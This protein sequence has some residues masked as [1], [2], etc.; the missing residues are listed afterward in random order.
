MSGRMLWTACTGAALATATVLTAVPSASRATAH[1]TAHTTPYA[2]FLPGARPAPA[3]TLTT[4]AP[5]TP[6]ASASVPSASVSPPSD[7]PS[8]GPPTPGAPS[9]TAGPSA[10]G[11]AGSPGVG[12]VGPAP[13]TPFAP[14]TVAG[15]LMRLQRLYREAEE[16][17]EAYNATEARLKRQRAEVA[18]LTAGLTKARRAL[19][20]SRV[21]AGR[22]AREQYQ[23][24]TELSG[25][26]RLL[27]A[28]DP[29]RALD[30]N[31][32]LE[33]AARGR[34]GTLARLAGGEKRADA[35]AAASRAALATQRSLA[36]KQRKQR[37]TVR[38]RLRAV[39]KL[40]ASLSREE[41]AALAELERAGT[42]QAQRD[43]LESG[44]LGD[45]PVP[46][47][48]VR[49]AGG[50]P[51]SAGTSGSPGRPGPGAG[52]RNDGQSGGSGEGARTPSR[53][54]DLAL[55]YAVRQIGK[56]YE[57]G[58]EGPDTFDC[59]GLTMQSW[60]YAGLTIPRTSQEQWRQLRR[61]PLRE[62]RPGDLVVYFEKA[63]H[64][65]IYLGEGMVIQAPRPGTRVKVSPIAAN[66]LLGAVRPDP[67]A[68]SLDPA[69]YRPPALPAGAT[70]GADTGYGEATA[71]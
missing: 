29:Q 1:T 5:G 17:T 9:G 28:R 26:L 53:Y 66:P 16:A 54:G 27:F 48:G 37:D 38:A 19:A 65:A 39:E 6:S 36:A 30:E 63:T 7:P 55:R 22:L 69:G 18:R 50:S 42:D 25:Y 23:G 21:D 56:P 35:L 68:E 46:S 15:M 4:S 12:A 2:V 62:L 52:V 49:G 64:I 60:A 70:D 20:L 58:A 24:R 32:L 51:G 33:H 71:P 3:P 41:I 31:Y 59:S 45:L 47:S 40:L 67:R 34:A 57:W 11:P 13:G 44:A 61:I 10:A 14:T 8:S 43:L